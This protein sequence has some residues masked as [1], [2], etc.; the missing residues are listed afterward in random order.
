M[1]DFRLSVSLDGDSVEFMGNHGSR[2]SQ[3]SPFP[4][5]SSS[6][7]ANNS[8]NNN[9]HENADPFAA[10]REM[11]NYMFRQ[12]TPEEASRKR[13]H[14]MRMMRRGFMSMGGIALLL[15]I[16]KFYL[17]KKVY[18]DH[19]ESLDK[20]A[21]HALQRTSEGKYY[22]SKKDYS[23]SYYSR[24]PASTNM[25]NQSQQQQQEPYEQQQQERRRT[26]DL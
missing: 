25:T 6:N 16:G 12:E 4:P 17:V 2:L 5:Q 7:H 18:F 14:R 8:S 13:A 21:E 1:Y 26:S 22:V 10:R 15:F 23:G 9:N 24:V 20:Q 11:Y 3:K 19:I